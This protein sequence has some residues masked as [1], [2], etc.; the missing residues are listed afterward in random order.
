MLN[1]AA[2]NLEDGGSWQSLNN[3]PTYAVSSMTGSN[4]MDQL[5]LYSGNLSQ[6]P[7]ADQLSQLYDKT[8]YIRLWANIGTGQ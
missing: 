7:H 8:D 1:D 2:W 6:V 4:I 5:N 3:F